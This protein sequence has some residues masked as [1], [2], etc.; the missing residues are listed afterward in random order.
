MAPT[1]DTQHLIPLWQLYGE[2]LVCRNGKGG[3]LAV[4]RGRH[5]FGQQVVEKERQAAL[6]FLCYP[7]RIIWIFLSKPPDT[8]EAVDGSQKAT[9]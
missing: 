6:L 4:Q 5:P 9:K 3:C 7:P 2:D 1:T 8:V